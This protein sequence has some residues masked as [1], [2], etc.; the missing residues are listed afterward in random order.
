MYDADT[1]ALLGPAMQAMPPSAPEVAFLEPTLEVW[2]CYEQ[3][4]FIWLYFGDYTTPLADRPPM[5][6]VPELTKAG[7]CT[8]D[9]LWTRLF[10][11]CVLL[12]QKHVFGIHTAVFSV[13]AAPRFL[14]GAKAGVRRQIESI[15]GNVSCWQVNVL[16]K[17]SAAA[18][19][20]VLCVVKPAWQTLV[21]LDMRT[22]SRA[23]AQCIYPTGRRK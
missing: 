6:S 17:Q 2:S 21:G 11:A 5:P 14:S 13:P 7:A 19:R 20:P 22:A 16:C 3:G 12:V 15:V 10:V 8:L 1:G 18:G 9:L 23:S 4:G